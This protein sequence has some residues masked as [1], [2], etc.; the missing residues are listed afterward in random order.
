VS[1]ESVVFGIAGVFFGVLVGWIIGSQQAGPTRQPSGAAAEAPAAQP[2][3]QTPALDESRAAALKAAADKNPKDAATRIELGNLY[4]DHQRFQDAV[5]WYEAA[6]VIDPRN[7]NVSTDLGIAYYYMNQPDLALK[8]FDRSL[9][10]EPRHTKTLLN[11]GVVRAFAKQDLEGAAKAWQRVVD[12]APTSP[13]ADRARQALASLRAAH[14]DGGG[15]Q[16]K[17]EPE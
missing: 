10:I 6:L 17:D 9:Q 8:Q 15:A 16:P 5:R 14:P 1:R 11:I 13:E 2:Q 4:F 3:A 7:V 12:V